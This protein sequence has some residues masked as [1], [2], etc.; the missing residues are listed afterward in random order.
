MCRDALKLIGIV[1][2]FFEKYVGILTPEYIVFF[3]SFLFSL[4]KWDWLS[5]P[6]LPL[7]LELYNLFSA[8]AATQMLKD[9]SQDG[10]YPEYNHTWLI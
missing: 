5:W 3:F 10:P 9:L 2:L 6:A 8:H 7:C 1:S 4:L